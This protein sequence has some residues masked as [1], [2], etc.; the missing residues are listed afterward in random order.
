VKKF[1]VL[2]AAVLAVSGCSAQSG[3]SAASSPSQPALAPSSAS[4]SP[5][6]SAAAGDWVASVDGA[7]VSLAVPGKA[8]KA[9][10]DGLALAKVPAGGTVVAT[11]DNRN[12]SGQVFISG[13]GV[14]DAD[15][16]RI[17]LQSAD[18]YIRPQ[19]GMDTKT[20]NKLVDLTNANLPRVEAG[21]KRDVVFM[22]AETPLPEVAKVDLEIGMGG[23]TVQATK[24]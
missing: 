19:S 18:S 12:G 14:M 16:K 22:V 4:S 2:C 8:P 15:G 10:S 23:R 21:E 24:S 20:Y 6:A 1:F 17:V 9:I 13:V 3:G 5:S 7:S 11:V